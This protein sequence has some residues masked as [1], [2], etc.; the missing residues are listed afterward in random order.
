MRIEAVVFDFDGLLMDTEGTMLASWQYEWRQHGLELDVAGFFADHGGDLSQ[1]RYAELALAV[2]PGFDRQASH[3]R[4]L[5]YR[6]GLN[7][8]LGLQPGIAQWLDE[9]VA[10]GLRLA[11]ATS[12]PRHWPLALLSRTGFLD[13][14]EV[15]ACGDEVAGPKPDP[16]VYQLA[17]TRLGVPPD[18]AV[19][20]EDT[21]HGVAAAQT[22]GMRCV[23]IPGPLADRTRFSTAELV[24]SSAAEASL[25]EVI[26]RVGAVVAEGVPQRS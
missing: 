15:L 2:G 17:L 20:V 9:A 25:A 3:T 11:I 26:A 13:R 7:A 16:G 23:A 18:V 6:D 10:L 21:A 1:H 5:A 22:T 24:L 14:F 19:A 12:S 4:R 8:R